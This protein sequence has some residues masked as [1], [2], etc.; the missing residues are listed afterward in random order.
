MIFVECPTV[1]CPMSNPHAHSRVDFFFHGHIHVLQ[2]SHPAS[3]LECQSDA[4]GVAVIGVSLTVKTKCQHTGNILDL[5]LVNNHDISA[6][7]HAVY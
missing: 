4:E 2:Q 5:F 7:N 3:F 6:E 1:H